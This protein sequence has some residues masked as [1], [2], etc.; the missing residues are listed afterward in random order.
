MINCTLFYRPTTIAL[1]QGQIDLVC[2][3]C[4][5]PGKWML[6]AFM[7]HTHEAFKCL[8][9]WTDSDQWPL[10][11]TVSSSLFCLSKLSKSVKWTGMRVGSSGSC[12]RQPE[13]TDQ[14]H[15]NLLF[16]PLV[17]SLGFQQLCQ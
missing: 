13:W 1:A 15:L 12:R 10:S 3:C 14:E 2:S 5:E 8:C 7:R 16:P 17:T 6:M 11:T 9:L 4:A